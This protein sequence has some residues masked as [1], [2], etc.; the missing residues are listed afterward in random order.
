MFGC[1]LPLFPLLVGAEERSESHSPPNIILF[2]ADDQ[3]WTGTSVAM[4]RSRNDSKSDFYRT[5]SLERLAKEGMRF[6]QGYAPHPNCSPTR[7]SIQTGKSPARL[8][9]TDI[10][11]VVSAESGFGR[12][13]Y[14]RFYLNKPM[15]VPLP[16]GGL[17]NEEVTIAE[18]IKEHRP[19]YATAHFGKWHMKGGSPS[20]HGYDQHDGPTSN[21]EGNAGEPDPKLI[22][23]I[24]TRSVKFIREQTA[25]NKPFFLQVSHYAVH[26]PV[27]AR[28]ETIGKFEAAEVGKV[29]SNTG[30]AAMTED[31]DGSLGILLS[32]LDELG[33]ADRTYV[34][35]TS[36]NGGEIGRGVGPTVNTPLAKGKTH[37]WEGGIRVPLIVRGPGIKA[38]AQ[39]NVSII[40]W[41][42][43]PTFAELLQIEAPLPKNMD[44]GSFA[45][46]LR[47]EGNGNVARPGNA[48]VWYY[49]HYRDMKG[50]RPQAA[51]RSG[52]FK[53]R[54]EFETGRLMLFDLNNDISESADLSSQNPEI[55]KRLHAALE[56]YL[57]AVGAKRPVLDPAYNPAKD[58]GRQGRGFRRGPRR[59]PADQ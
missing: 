34:I 45:G 25:A 26:T 51:I 10:L 17:P 8:G 3:G 24:T 56:D 41:D 6:S 48:F 27:F 53:L 54:K 38:G 5:P 49:P 12:I 58:L 35:Y 19:A 33:V 15:K 43:F 28:S 46:I 30:Y 40:G 36:D 57:S 14:E 1:I 18:F 39:S 21:A 16:I 4:D 42:F 22:G 52:D 32:V 23:A 7:M 47:N 59:R 50:V 11:D 9:S 2:L 20:D 31:L 29:H 37:T 44:G 55:T 13:F